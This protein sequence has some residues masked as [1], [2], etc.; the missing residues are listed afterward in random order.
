MPSAV[1]SE[2]SVHSGNAFS[3]FA[4]LASLDDNGMTSSIPE[5]NEIFRRNEDEDV[6]AS[7][8]KVRKS[9]LDASK[10]GGLSEKEKRLNER[11]DRIERG[12]AKNAALIISFPPNYPQ[13]GF[14][15]F[16]L[17]SGGLASSSSSLRSDIIAELAAIA[18]GSTVRV[19]IGSTGQEIKEELTSTK[20]LFDVAEC[21]R[22]RTLQYWGVK[23]NI[24]PSKFVA[25]MPSQATYFSGDS[26]VRSPSR[27]FRGS[28]SFGDIGLDIDGLS[29][30]VAS[31]ACINAIVDA[32]GSIPEQPIE[33][34][35]AAFRKSPTVVVV[36]ESEHR[37]RI[38][39]DDMYDGN[40]DADKQ[41]RDGD[42]EP[43][44]AYSKAT[45]VIDPMAY[46][47]PCPASSGGYFAPSGALMTF[48]GAKFV[49][50]TG[51]KIAVETGGMPTIKTDSDNRTGSAEKRDDAN[52][53]NEDAES[54][55]FMQNMYPKSYADMLLRQRE[56]EFYESE[57]MAEDER[58]KLNNRDEEP[59]TTQR[60]ISGD[61]PNSRPIVKSSSGVFFV[62]HNLN[63]DTSDSDRENTE[64]E[65]IETGSGASS[66]SDESEDAYQETHMA[67]NSLYTNPLVYGAEMD[68]DA[69]SKCDCNFRN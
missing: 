51:S 32:S 3:D 49:V 16:T 42:Q 27:A 13:I 39:G 44:I 5:Q 18:K 50:K 38:G 58:G 69:L 11:A 43:G 28:G 54:V 22:C 8:K 60:N 62:D 7:P 36:A 47:V 6:S 20:L 12:K 48:G 40:I 55:R 17:R 1:A 31:L 23:V 25:Q 26:S 67:R 30:N 66:G 29:D 15:T 41:S 9:S 52:I 24:P 64:D 45:M 19:T 59:G 14:P 35:T 37:R 10:T 56:R 21:F 57:K 4:M 53:T 61:N 63:S 65:S 2:K 46:Y 34:N 33:G 68:M